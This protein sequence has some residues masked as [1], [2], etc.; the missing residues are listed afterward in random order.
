MLKGWPL[1]SARTQTQPSFIFKAKQTNKLNNY[2]RKAANIKTTKIA[3][4]RE[5]EE[6]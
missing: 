4:R 2:D 3:W 1:K 6:G 5:E